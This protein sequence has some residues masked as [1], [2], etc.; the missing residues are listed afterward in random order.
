[1]MAFNKEGRGKMKKIDIYCHVFPRID[2]GWS[3][4]RK[5]LRC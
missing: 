2:D 1:M 5:A 4:F 3:P